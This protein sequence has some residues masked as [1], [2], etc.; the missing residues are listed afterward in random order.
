MPLMSLTPRRNGRLMMTVRVAHDLGGAQLAAV[1]CRYTNVWDSYGPGVWEKPPTPGQ[2]LSRTQFTD[3]I[4]KALTAAGNGAFLS[5]DDWST[6]YTAHEA[7]LIATWAV[8]QISRLYPGLAAELAVWLK[9]YQPPEHTDE[10]EE[11]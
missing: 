8:A 6:D 1:L 2:E 7:T 4:R 5:E 11:L 3:L 9:D 10:D